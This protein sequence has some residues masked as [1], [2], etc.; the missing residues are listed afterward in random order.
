M[1]SPAY[2]AQRSE[3]ARSLGLGQQRRKA[4]SAPEP[5]A[6]AQEGPEKAKRAARPRKVAETTEA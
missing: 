4:T 1:V 6:P 5:E 3:L 2:S